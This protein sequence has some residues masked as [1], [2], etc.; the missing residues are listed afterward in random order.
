VCTLDKHVNKLFDKLVSQCLHTLTCLA[1]LR[2]LH[3]CT[4][5][6]LFLLLL[7]LFYCN[8]YDTVLFSNIVLEI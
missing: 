6:F 3:L 2:L 8:Y 4:L 5:L 7:L 1:H